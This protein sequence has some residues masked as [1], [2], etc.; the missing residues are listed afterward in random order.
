MGLALVLGSVEAALDLPQYPLLD[1]PL[2]PFRERLV[3]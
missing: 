2:H 3:A 1:R